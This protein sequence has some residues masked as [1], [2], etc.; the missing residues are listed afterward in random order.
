MTKRRA[1]PVAKLLDPAFVY[2]SAQASR[3]PG[4]LAD[5]FAAIKAELAEQAAALSAEQSVKVR[6]IGK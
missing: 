6:K 5:R 4:Y 2:A 1:K 3:A